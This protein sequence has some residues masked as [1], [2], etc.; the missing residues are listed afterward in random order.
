MNIVGFAKSGDV[1]AN[2]PV[3]PDDPGVRRVYKRA[4]FESVW[5]PVSRS[6]GIAYVVHNAHHPLPPNVA[7]LPK[8]W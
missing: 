6:G 1:I 7:G 5:I 8:N 2:D 3:S 4:Q